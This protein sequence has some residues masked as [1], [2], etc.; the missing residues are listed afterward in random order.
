MSV[1]AIVR[2]RKPRTRGSAPHSPTLMTTEA[3][4]LAL[5]R[6]GAGQPLS[7]SP[8]MAQCAGMGCGDGGRGRAM[9]H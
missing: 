3:G 7:K 6:G 9:L 2:V 1:T 4:S 5:L 8:A